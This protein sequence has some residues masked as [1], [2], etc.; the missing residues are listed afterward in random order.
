[1]ATLKQ[2]VLDIVDE[3]ALL[4]EKNKET[5]PHNPKEHEDKTRSELAKTFVLGYFILLSVAFL[6]TMASNL[7]V[8]YLKLDQSLIISV[9]DIILTI[10]ST[11]GTSLGFVVGYYFKS[12]E[13]GYNL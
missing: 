2:T 5:L 10:S 1:M 8:S 13:N 3:I 9:K 6:L 4:R 12:S 11:I 7:T